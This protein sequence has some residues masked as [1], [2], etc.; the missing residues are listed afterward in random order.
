MKWALWVA[1]STSVLLGACADS[2]VVLSGQQDPAAF[3]SEQLEN[4]Q[5]QTTASPITPAPVTT[6]T[7]AAPATTATVTSTTAP[8]APDMVVDQYSLGVGDCFNREEVVESQQTIMVVTLRDCTKTHSH[9]VFHTFSYPAPYPSIY[10]GD[11]IMADFALQSCYG[12]FEQW[13]GR[14]YETSQLDIATTTPNQTN[15]E[16][17]AARYR[18]VHCHVTH[19][20]SELLV[21]DAY[22]SGW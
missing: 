20:E 9:Q 22:Q 15:F 4:P 18:T 2:S 10:P 14:P 21:G 19:I 12:E 11:Q 17:E 13:V 16:D 7:L 6:A 3:V 8:T 5:L 1:I